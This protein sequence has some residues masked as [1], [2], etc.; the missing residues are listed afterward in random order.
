MDETQQTTDVLVIG[1]GMAG[2]IAAAELQRAGH[3]VLVLDKGRGVGG[4]LASRRIDGATFDHG[5]QFI[6]ARDPR[7]AALLEQCRQTGAA[8]EWCLGFAGGADGHARWRG[9][10]AM[11]AVAKHLALGLDL[12][13]EMPVVALRRA[14]DCWRAETTTG[15]TFTTG[16]VVLTPPVPQSLAMLDAGG[17][18]L[19]PEMR[20]R[21]AAIEYARCLAVMAVLDGPSRIPP[22][23]GLAP[24]DGPIAWIADNALKG[25]SAEPAVTI[26]ATHAFSLK[27]WERDRQESGRALLDA[28]APWLGAGIRTFQVHGWR[29]SKPMQVDEEPCVVVSQ[30]PPLVLAGDAFAGPRVEGAALSGWAAAEAILTK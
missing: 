6:T 29:Y 10:P 26:H 17:I 1:A 19:A 5:A 9:K 3:R 22:P 18:V 8:E 25:I 11:S 28:A 14:D 4:R 15:R 13:L 24:A 23:G 20:T 7:F 27:H 2:L 30:S 12:H 21:L 16:A